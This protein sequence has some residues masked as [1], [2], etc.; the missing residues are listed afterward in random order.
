MAKIVR[1]SF[2]ELIRAQWASRKH[3]CVGLDADASKLPPSLRP[4]DDIAVRLLVF[5]E[6]II[7]ATC[8]LVCAYKPNSAYY[9]AI[10]SDGIEALAKTIEYINIHA[11]Q[12]PV[13]IDGKRGDIGNT[14]RAYASFL[15]DQMGA[16]AATVQPYFGSEALKPILDRKDKHAFVIARTSNPGAGEFQDLMV[17]GMPL[18][19]HVAK[20]V[21]TTWNYNGNCGLVVGATYPDELRRVRELVPD[22]VPIL[23]PGVGS[24]GGDLVSSVGAA[25]ANGGSGFLI[26]VSRSIIFSSHGP[27]F[28]QAARDKTGQLSTTINEQISISHQQG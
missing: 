17:E 15:Y 9:E 14:N 13:I 21:A 5:N 23:V 4:D 3:L 16:D 6:R 7:D 2:I 10:G 20:A 25:A 24:Q 19:L 8:N 18:Y 26:N 27:D 12:V 28:D 22:E 1:P 11:P